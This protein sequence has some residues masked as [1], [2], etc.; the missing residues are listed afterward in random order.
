MDIILFGFPRLIFSGFICKD[1]KL[2]G[3]LQIFS[4]QIPIKSV[5]SNSF[6]TYQPT[7][8]NLREAQSP[9]ERA[10]SS[11]VTFGSA[12]VSFSFSSRE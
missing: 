1:I 8:I 4:M 2:Y 6:S 11:S 5:N 10:G 7:L 3:D 9:C 12:I